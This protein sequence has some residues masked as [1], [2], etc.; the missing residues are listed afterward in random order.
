[1]ADAKQAVLLSGGGAHGAFQVGVLLELYAVDQLHYDV[2]RGV[3]VGALNGAVIAQYARKDQSLAAAHAERL[4]LTEVTGSDSVYRK[5]FGGDLG[6]LLAGAQGLYDPSPLQQIVNRNWPSSGARVDFAVGAVD[7]ITGEYVEYPSTHPRFA[8]CIVHSARFP[9]AFD[10]GTLVEKKDGVRIREQWLVD[11][12]V[13]NIVPHR[14]V[15]TDPSITSI[16]V[17]AC[18][19]EMGGVLPW[20]PGKHYSLLEYAMRNAEILADEVFL[21]DMEALRS[22][23]RADLRRRLRVFAPSALLTTDPLS[24]RA[25]DVPLLIAYGRECAKKVLGRAR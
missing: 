1:M 5:R 12:G 18:K 22:W 17:I 20:S 7:A 8:E 23:A 24:F 16:D 6:A 15:L 21:G 19:P 10:P 3:S 4:W 14:S 11:G 2:V 13:R 9:L 25:S